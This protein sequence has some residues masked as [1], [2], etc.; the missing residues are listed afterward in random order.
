MQVNNG[1]Y[2]IELTIPYNL[3]TNAGRQLGLHMSEDGSI[4]IHRNVYIYIM[5]MLY[6]AKSVGNVA[7]MLF[8]GWTG[9]EPFEI[10]QGVRKA[11]HCR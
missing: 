9:F 3:E 4:T 8:T 1:R 11:A 5:I 10:R 7:W 6:P 2:I